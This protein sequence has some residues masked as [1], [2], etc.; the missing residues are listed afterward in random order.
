VVALFDEPPKRPDR[1]RIAVCD[2]F[3]RA[4]AL[5]RDPRVPLRL[6]LLTL[7]GAP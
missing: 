1:N 7:A 3:A 6:K 2:G 4:V 5:L